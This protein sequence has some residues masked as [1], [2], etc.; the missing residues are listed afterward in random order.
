MLLRAIDKRARLGEED[1]R[2]RAQMNRTLKNFDMLKDLLEAL[3]KIDTRDLLRRRRQAGP[4]PAGPEG[5]G[6]P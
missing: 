6:R 1:H 2:L 3:K 5:G 4:G